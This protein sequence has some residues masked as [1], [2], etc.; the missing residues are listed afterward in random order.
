MNNSAKQPVPE[1]FTDIMRRAFRIPLDSAAAYLHGLGISPNVVTLL[2]LL[3]V[4]V[5]SY[6]LAKGRFNW[7]MV[8]LLSMAPFDALDGALARLNGISTPFGAMLDSFS[9]R[10]AEL[11]IYG[12]LMWYFMQRGEFIFAI[13][14]LGAV[15]G[16]V[17]VS[18]ARARAESLGAEMKDGWFSRVERLLVLGL[19]ILLHVPAIGVVIVALGANATAVQRLWLAYKRLS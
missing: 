8:I 1:T 3:G 5:G 12:G 14:C 13:L 4:M 10:Y 19:A 17:M 15:G 9:D 6:F 2:G 18:Y 11:F 7:A 16:S